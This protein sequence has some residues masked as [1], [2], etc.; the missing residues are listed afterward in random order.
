M[1]VTETTNIISELQQR[2]GADVV[3][4]QP[5][6][7]GIPTVW[8]APERVKAVLRYLKTEAPLPYPMLLDLTAIDERMRGNR[9]GQPASDFTVVYQLLSPEREGDIR[10]KVPLC[11]ETPALETVTDLWVNANWYEREMWDMFGITPTGHHQL[12]RLLLPPWWEGH[13][14]RKEYPARATELGP[15]T[16]DDVRRAGE[17]GQL[18]FRP[19]EWGMEAGGEDFDY[20][21]L[22]VGPH[23]PGTHGVLRV[24]VQM[25]GQEIVDLVCDIGYHHRAAEKMGERQSWHT[26]IPYTDRVDYLAGVLN[27]LPYVM[28]VERL[29][30]IHVPDRARVIR[31]MLA[32]LCR[33]SSHLVFLG[34][35]AQDLGMMSPT[36]YAFTDRERAFSIIEAI[37]GGRMHPA[38]FRIGGVAADLPNGWDGMVRDFIAYMGR[39]IRDYRNAIV[40]NAI[41]RA[42]S[43]GV[44]QFTTADALAWGA[45]GP[46]LRGT[47]FAWDLRKVRPY[48]GYDQFDFEVPV[49]SN[50]DAYDRLI[51][52]VEEM[53]QSLR[54][55]EQCLAVMPAG[56]YKAKHP[57]TTPP[58]KEH[59]MGDIE[60][61]IGHF[62]GVSWGPVIPAG[63]AAVS[64]ESSKGMMSYYL[65]SDG[66][67][68]SYRT[69]I[70]TPSFPHVQ[71]VP[72]MTRGFTISDLITNLASLDFMLAEVDR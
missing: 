60:T 11:G 41:I 62:V 5:T 24:I 27:E 22:N 15:F 20:L 43:R 34:T 63:E 47:G 32:E 57:L 12:R 52:H 23:H 64:I 71:M 36:F 14:L 17:E 8:A 49:G 3:T 68:M 18:Q 61:L 9:A 26:Y 66:N 1:V 19:E 30:G 16:M 65:V 35:F 58:L 40:K 53:A 25:H 39:Q 51:V 29:A 33:I 67:T 31:I 38:W 28:A 42:R 37:T 44:G 48:G 56:P 13:P 45:S 6:A 50:G 10:I 2:F 55:M 21:F 70:R 7:D 72:F 4:P 59:T 54:I 69:R 46:M